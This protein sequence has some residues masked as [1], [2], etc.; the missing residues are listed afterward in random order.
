MDFRF[1]E[2]LAAQYHSNSQKIRVMSERWVENNVFC[3]CCGNP[4]IIKLDNNS[5]VADFQCNYCGEIFELKSKNGKIDNKIADGAYS[6]MI[7]RITS[8]T[9]PD[10]FI[11]RY[12]KHL[13]VLDMT[14]I[15]KF[16]FVPQIIER[17][18]PLAETARRAGW[19]GCNILLSE[20]PKQG[21]IPIII[22]QHMV[23]ISSVVEQYRKITEIK[24]SNIESRSWLFDVLNC[25]NQINKVQFSLQEVYAFTEELHL[26]HPENHNIDAKIRQQLQLLRDKDIIEFVDRGIY[27]KRQ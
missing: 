23:E 4:H 14:V 5:P 9:N 25:V 19:V 22:N 2:N 6:T 15:P 17:R 8:T 7:E 3:P 26:K 11:L 13:E 10:L 16:F 27:R 24:M 18:K 21:R 20:I 1:D 12:S